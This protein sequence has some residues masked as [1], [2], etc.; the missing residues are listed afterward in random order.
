MGIEMYLITGEYGRRHCACSICKELVENPV[1][2]KR[3]EHVFCK[4]C[5]ETHNDVNPVFKRQK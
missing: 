1:M 2:I 4:T 5:L 3:C